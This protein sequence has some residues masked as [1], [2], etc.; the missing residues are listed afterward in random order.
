[1]AGVAA[2]QTQTP[3]LA[4]PAQAAA[5][6]ATAAPAGTATLRGHVYD[7]TNALIPGAT[8]TITT[9]AGTQ[10]ATATADAAGAY[11]VEGLAPGSYVVQASYAGFA[12]FNSPAIKLA[13]GQVMHVKI[14]MAVEAEQQS[15]VVTDESPMVSVDAGSNASAIVLK[16][17]D[18]DALSDDPD[19][20]SN[21]LEALAGPSAGPN[22]GQIY[23]DGF[24]GGTLPPKSAIREIRINRNPFSAEYD[25]IG[26]GRIEILTKPGT[27][28][29]HGRAFVMGNDSLFNTGNPFVSS[30]PDYH[31]IQYNGTV[32]GSLNKKT[33]FTFTLEGRNIQ[34]DNI[35]TASTAVLNPATGLYSIPTDANG[36]II[37]VT[38]SVFSPST[39]IEVSPRIDLQMGAKDTLTLRYQYERGSQS[40]NLGGSTSLPATATLGNSSEHSIQLTDS[41]IIND[42]IVNET[43]FQYRRAISSTTPVSTAPSVGV[44]GDFSGGGSGGQFNNDHTDHL[45]LQNMTTMSAGAHAIK[46]GTW[47]RDNRDANSSDA[48]FNG[49][50]SFPSLQA[51]VSTLNGLAQGET[52]AQIAASCPASQTGGCLPNN[53]TY[54]TGKQAVLG[55]VFDAALYFQDDWKVNRIFTFS[56]GL[57]WET[58]NHTADHSDFAPRFAFAYALDGH[59][60]KQQTKTV[61]RGGYGYFYDRFQTGS[62]MSLERFNSSSNSQTQISIANPKCFNAVSLSD[63]SGGLASCG[64]GTAATPEIYQIAPSYHAP[65]ME[66]LGTSLERQVTKTTSATLTFLHTYGV[67][68]MATR[69]SNAY[70]PLPGTFFYNSTTGPRP[71]PNLG[72]VRE[73]F[74]EAVFKQNQVIANINARFSTKFSIMGFYDLSFAN[75][76]TGTASNSYNLKQ[77]YGSAPFASRNMIFLMGNYTGPW[78]ISFNPFLVAQSGKPFN[79]TTNNDLTGDSFFNDRPSYAT[80][81]S[82]A[83][84]VVQTGFGTFD[85]VPQSGETIIPVNM[86]NGP[87]AVAVNLRVSRS[88]GIG[89]KTAS[90]ANQNNTGGPPPGGGPGG[91]G[92][93]PGGP[94]GPGGGPGGGGPGGGGPGG[95]MGGMGGAR[96]GGGG[97]GGGGF[98]GGGGR[99]GGGGGG[100]GGAS[101]A[102]TGHKYS[103]NFSAQALNLFNDINYGQPSGNLIPTFNSTTGLYGPGSRFDKSTSLARGLGASP[104]SSAARRIMF[105]AAFSF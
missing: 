7:P 3:A 73:F 43:H 15:V 103:L 44:S 78:G 1:M 90:A 102:N 75:A 92:G 48:N 11:V 32:G 80:S 12:Q 68:Q 14:V 45:E 25:H 62:L 91:P 20:L 100:R 88:F 84:N 86:V 54:T 104:T 31:S 38:G 87:A 57:R 47:L 50:F 29:M 4:T 52:F 53:L 93:G 94:G 2:A 83:G 23:I 97:F 66:Q 67:H 77:D 72:I 41:H 17:A 70:E 35:Y 71:N 101:A 6:A 56:G 89:P 10:A 33:S 65:Y 5:P 58:Q 55:N 18:L 60:D 27:D 19:E 98:G 30:I 59:K 28:K 99:G 40:G 63:I 82:I 39:R 22:G 76:D 37:P 51:Y 16:G 74:P 49:S 105:Q 79:I 26:Y 69:D 34:D 36:N 46:F 21:E 61:L 8:I 13:A 42:R 81:A 96:G 64:T 85:T 9:P 95:G 24:T